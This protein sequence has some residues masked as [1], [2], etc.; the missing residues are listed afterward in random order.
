MSEN[1]GI[2]IKKGLKIISD[3]TRHLELICRVRVCVT[4]LA[5]FLAGHLR[6]AALELGIEWP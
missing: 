5:L 2:K 6:V 4:F 3:D 1:K